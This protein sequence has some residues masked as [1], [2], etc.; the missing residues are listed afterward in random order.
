MRVQPHL[1]SSPLL[2][3][4]MSRSGFAFKACSA[5]NSP[6]PPEPRIRMSVLRC[7]TFMAS[8]EYAHE[9][10]ET[11]EGRYRVRDGRELFLAVPPIEILDHQNTQTAEQMHGEQKHQTAF[12]ELDQRLIAPAQ[13][14]IEPR[15]AVDGEPARQKMQR[16]EN[17]QRQTGD[18]VP[19][20]GEPQRAVAMFYL[21]RNH[22]STTAATARKPSSASVSPNP[23]ANRPPWRSPSGDH[24]H[25]ILRMPIAA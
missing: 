7:S 11:Y 22:D 19:H 17:R 18:A 21:P 1:P 10:Q 14:T 23:I 4:V 16:Q 13:E 9:K 3:T 12:R 2:A 5:P 8:S 25:K 24:S 20:G 6:A 15:R